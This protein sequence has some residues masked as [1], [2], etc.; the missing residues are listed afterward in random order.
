MALQRV[1]QAELRPE[2]GAGRRVGF[3]LYTFIVHPQ[4]MYP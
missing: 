2:V 1:D 4:R 3:Q